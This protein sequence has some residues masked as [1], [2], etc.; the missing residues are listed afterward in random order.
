MRNIRKFVAPEIIFGVGALELV[1]RYAVNFGANRVFI[2]TDVGI[3]QTGL[4]DRTR[5]ILQQGEWMR[6]SM[7]RSVPIPVIWR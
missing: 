4:L 6:W 2:V 3:A 5:Q 7:T 1:G